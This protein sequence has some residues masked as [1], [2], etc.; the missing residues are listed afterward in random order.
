MLIPDLV[1]LCMHAAYSFHL[2][3]M[4]PCVDAVTW[5]EVISKASYPCSNST[6]LMETPFVECNSDRVAVSM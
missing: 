5:S 1:M 2:T 4:F 6:G 3:A